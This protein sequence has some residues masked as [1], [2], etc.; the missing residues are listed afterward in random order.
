ML[1]SEIRLGPHVI[2]TPAV[3][4]A[5]AAPSVE[6]MRKLVS[7]AL[8]DGA[9]II[10]LRIDFLKRLDGWEA[11]IS[12]EVPMILTVR[13]KREGGNFK[14][15]ESQRIK[16]LLDG[17]SKGTSAVDL[18]FSTPP[19]LREKVLSRAKETGA[20]VIL[21]YHD[22]SGRDSPEKLLKLAKRMEETGGDILKVVTMAKD[23]RG[24]QKA[25]EFL[26]RA[27]A[28]FKKPLVTFA[29]G[30]AG[31]LTR[32]IGR[33]FGVPIVYAAVAKRTA[34]GQLGVKETK[35]LLI[36]LKPREVKD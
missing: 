22:F 14:G 5:V 28:E 18:E 23:W 25:L 2:Q 24:V 8:A 15:G 36:Q 7:Q 29:M 1:E 9:D 35:D 16:L 19:K 17:L 11:L 31:I 20:S 6:E 34:P 10:E 12:R 21:S 32:F 30:E 26:V 27:Q 3:C 13:P 4:G 33:I